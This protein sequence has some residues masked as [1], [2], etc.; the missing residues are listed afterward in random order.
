MK[1]NF[2]VERR[3]LQEFH[4][5]EL[6]RRSRAWEKLYLDLSSK[7]ERLKNGDEFLQQMLLLLF[8]LLCVCRSID[9]GLR[10]IQRSGR[11]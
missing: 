11:K 5:D 10:R 7:H 1:M 4:E 2:E 9:E 8:S 6:D 3:S